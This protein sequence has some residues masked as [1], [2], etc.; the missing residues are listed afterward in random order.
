[1]KDIEQNSIMPEK[2][3][4]MTTPLVNHLNFDDVT[5]YGNGIL[6]GRVADIPDLYPYTRRYLHQ[7]ATIN[8]SL[9]DQE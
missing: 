7:I 6:L 1:M 4:D 9:P 2:Y 3:P 8:H 5:K